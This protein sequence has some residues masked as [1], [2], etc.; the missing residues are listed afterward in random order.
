MPRFQVDDP[1]ATD[2]LNDLGNFTPEWDVPAVGKAFTDAFS[3][4]IDA[5]R[6]HPEPSPARKVH[7]VLGQ[8]GYGKTHLLGRIGHAQEGRAYFAFIPSPNGDT[9][10]EQFESTLRW[11][12]VESL[13]YSARTFAPVREQLAKLFAP[14]F[15]AYFG[16]LPAG[17]K[18]KTDDLRVRLKD[19]PITVLEVFAQVE[20]LGPYHL[21]ADALRTRLPN[22]SGA[23]LRALM[24]AASPAA[25]DARWWLRGEA[26][27]IPEV[28][29]LALN[30][31]DREKRPLPSPP[32]I[33]ILRAIAELLRLTKTPL[34]VCFDQLEELFKHNRAGVASLTGH[35]MSWLQ[36]VPNLL[37]GVGCMG[38]VWNEMRVKGGLKSFFDRVIEHTL[39]EL[40][41]NEA[42]EIVRRRVQTWTDYD[43]KKGDGW[44]FDLE[45]VRAYADK[46]QPGPRYFIQAECARGFAD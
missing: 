45:S 17:W 7:A 34:V 16:Q 25:D 24:L 41:G 1:F 39:P 22:C 10:G 33:D 5:V 20:G 19:D 32:L 15:A 8:A 29:L 46:N 31:V 44:P 43:P 9:S 12:L 4:A 23:V 18:A 38:D 21:L 30:L 26:D 2:R 36:T 13:L 11:R 40:S 37:I 6:T 27:Q 35:L 14:S 42:V 28:R 3:A